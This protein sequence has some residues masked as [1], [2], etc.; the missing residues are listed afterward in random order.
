MQI[1]KEEDQV[2]PFV[3]EMTVYI[4][5]LKNSTRVLLQRI[6]NFNNMARHKVNTNKSVAFL[7]TNDKWVK[8]EIR[9][10]TPF[11]IATNNIKYHRVTLSK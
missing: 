9:K 1:G 4:S 6:N 5:D 11:T 8:K 10:T 3:D 2:S 7:Y